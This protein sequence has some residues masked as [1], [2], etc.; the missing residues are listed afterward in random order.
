[1]QQFN[2]IEAMFAPGGDT[3]EWPVF[4]EDWYEESEG[5]EEPDPDE[6]DDAELR[7]LMERISSYIDSSGLSDS[8]SLLF[9]GEFLLLTLAN[10]IWFQSGRAD[11]TPQMRVHL[12]TI[13]LL[14]ADTWIEEKPFEIVVEGHTDNVPMNT[15]AFPNNWWLS[16]GR[17]ANCIKLL[18]DESGLPSMYF[19]IK[20][21]GEERPLADN[22]TAEGRQSNRRVEIRISM[23]RENDSFEKPDYTDK[24]LAE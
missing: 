21:H 19:S 3:G 14:L 10:D 15:P 1:M 20:G 17:A 5:A 13:A 8:I 7:E 24:P 4:P 23:F 6:V 16:V 2:E 18:I 22:N 11:I 9:D 12:E